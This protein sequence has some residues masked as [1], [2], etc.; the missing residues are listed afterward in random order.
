MQSRRTNKHDGAAGLRAPSFHPCGRSDP[1][2]YLSHHGL[3]VLLLLCDFN[4]G[5]LGDSRHQEVH[6]DVLAVGQ[7]VHHVLQAGG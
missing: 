3:F 2:P 1:P 4:G 7:L 5:Q 6:Q